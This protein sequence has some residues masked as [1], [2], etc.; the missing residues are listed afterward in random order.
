M[1]ATAT[2]NKL[3]FK[4]QAAP[5]DNGEYILTVPG[6]L[7][8][9]D[10]VQGT[11]LT[12]NY[13]LAKDAEKVVSYT[14]TPAADA[15]GKVSTISPIVV[16][17]ANATTVKDNP[18]AN[19]YTQY[20]MVEYNSPKAGWGEIEISERKIENK[21]LLFFLS[22]QDINEGEFKLTIPKGTYLID[23]VENPEIIQTFNYAVPVQDYATISPAA[24]QYTSLQEFKV[25]FNNATTVAFVEDAFRNGKMPK[26]AGINGTT[27]SCSMAASGYGA[28]GN[29]LTFKI[30]Y[31][32]FTTVGEY[33]LQI[34]GECFTVDG[35]AGQ[36]ITSGTY[37]IIAGVNTF[38]YTVTPADSTTVDNFSS[39]VVKFP[40]A[41]AITVDEEAEYPVTLY[42]YD[43]KW[44]DWSELDTNEPT[45]TG[46]ELTITPASYVKL[47]NGDYKVV[48]N[49]NYISVDGQKFTEKIESTFTLKQAVPEFTTVISPAQGTV[50]S[51]K[52]FNIVFKD[53]DSFAAN[54]NSAD[55]KYYIIDGQGNKYYS[56]DAFVNQDAEGSPLYI[57][58]TEITT[59]GEYKL[60]LPANSYTVNGIYGNE[61]TYSYTVA[62][63]VNKTAYTVTINGE[64]LE[65]GAELTKYDTITVEFPN[66]NK[67]EVDFNDYSKAIPTVQQYS[68][69]FGWGDAYEI[70][71][72]VDGNKII[73]ELASYA[74]DL[75]GGEYRVLVPYDNLSI[76][77]DSIA[78]DIIVN[79]TIKQVVPEFT[80][81]SDPADGSTVGSLQKFD[82][83]FSGV[84]T[85]G[86][87]YDA[88]P[89]ILDANE[90]KTTAAGSQVIAI[91]IDDDNVKTA[92]HIEFEDAITANGT[93]TLVLPV[94][95]YTVEGVKGDKE[96]KFTYTVDSSVDGVNN[97]FVD[98]VQNVDVYN[99]SG[100]R[101][102]KN[103]TPA[104]V[105]DLDA[106][107]YI[108]NGQKIRLRK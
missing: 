59:P 46:N 82:I 69:K 8:T 11:D 7:Y 3:S 5:S 76:D 107:I 12:F 65:D 43:T 84:S 6:A 13:T 64:T 23:D 29:V 57:A 26:L 2:G 34:P 98:G 100:V 41:A 70:E 38:E 53:V 71:A 92:L 37:T 77:G 49:A 17:F 61:L 101:V 16:E 86:K 51:L 21:S 74:S 66:A 106:N 18:N 88:D 79:F 58:F 45:V 85:F 50:S 32:E 87:G 48:I 1:S 36:D 90:L 62:T 60:V 20:A 94:G 97:I 42:V 105:R 15:N 9:L 25:T 56:T 75:E 52:E 104:Q 99:L 28:E 91:P 30:G 83:Y 14:I 81:T 108:V 63:P 102:L 24:G 40:N 93:Y 103:A 95:S 96:L 10:G 33:Q 73:F 31:S 47:A 39:Y 89:Y 35:A 80:V 19:Y 27:A 22:D 44:N 68:A 67:V 78:A 4:T 55:T 72:S 54:N